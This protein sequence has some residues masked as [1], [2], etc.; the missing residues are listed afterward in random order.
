[1]TR[2]ESKVYNLL[3]ELK[4][5][6]ALEI[7]VK[8]GMSRK[9]VQ[10]C[11]N[12]QAAR[13]VVEKRVLGRRAVVYCAK[14]GGVSR[15]VKRDSPVI[16]TKT[17]G[18]MERVLELLSRYGCVS[19]GALMR[20]MGIT[21]TQAYHM[22]RVLLFTRQGVKMRIGK[23]AVLCRDR[24]VAEEIVMRIRE[25]VHRLAVAN[26]MR[27]ATATKILQVALID[28]EAYELLSRFIPLRR[29]MTRFPP[30][31]LAFIADVLEALYG[32]SLKAGNK[33]VYAVAPQPRNYVPDVVDN[34]E[35]HTARVK[36]P[37][38]L[39]L[40]GEKMIPISFHL[41]PAMLQRLDEYAREKNMTRSAVIR[42]AIAEML[43][44]M[45]ELSL[46]QVVS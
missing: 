13:G 25:M 27:Y 38:R 34:V 22:L 3:K 24:V 33:R 30:S 21:H 6:T 45:K 18:R 1:M 42:Y 16:Y 12:H 46:A 32:K 29:N 15:H 14:E 4:C 41:P 17:R 8:L 26:G 20:I 2:T 36:P 19:V 44:K 23:T 43:E 40:F 31:I 5:A 11:L 9:V 7:A 37:R 39:L 35:T 28:R 10:T